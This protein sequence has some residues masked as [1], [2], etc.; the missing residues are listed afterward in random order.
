MKKF[1]IV[2]VVAGLTVSTLSPVFA[3]K[4]LK[5]AWSE[6]YA[7]DKANADFK[8]L[9]DEAKC[10]VCHVDKENKKKVRNPYGE[11]MHEAL[12]KDEFPVKD[13]KKD[14]AKFAERLLAIF[15]QVEAAESGDE[16]HKTF[17]DRMKANLL[18]GGNVDGKKE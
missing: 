9:A 4:Q 14:Q 3:F 5:D 15:K 7:G 2:L 13:F 17:A 12:E 11:A 1:W 6:H 18:P 10:N 16:T 8:K